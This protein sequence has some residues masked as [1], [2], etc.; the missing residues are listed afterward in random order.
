M[1]K[2]IGIVLLIVLSITLSGCSSNE[3]EKN[4]M[5]EK[6]SFAEWSIKNSNFGQQ[7]IK[8]I[9]CPEINENAIMSGSTEIF[10][11]D[12]K[13]YKYDTDKLFSNDKNCKLVGKIEGENG[14]A[15]NRDNAIDENG[16]LYNT[17]WQKVDDPDYN[18]DYVKDTFHDGWKEYFKRFD[19]NKSM[20]SGGLS[21]NNALDYEIIT[22]ND[23]DLIAYNIDYMNY[24]EYPNG[25]D[26]VYK[27]NID[28]INDEKIIKIYSSIIKTDKA[29]YSISSRKTNKEQCDKYADVKCEYEYFL[30]KEEILSKYY[31][32]IMNISS[33]YFITYN[34]ELI[35][36][37]VLNYEP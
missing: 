36:M 18:G 27:I 10:I 12:N 32:E 26:F 19:I 23:N 5:N 37:A 6:L 21:I 25:K 24:G 3:K 11:T 35:S 1:R 13:I 7:E 4:D 34:Y 29:F 16:I 28:N 17:F 15:V 30:K 20:I 31:E 2:Y 8:K 33:N 14:I 22:L 9:N